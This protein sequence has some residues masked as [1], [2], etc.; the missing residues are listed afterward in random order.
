MEGNFD[1]VCEIEPPVRPDLKQVRHQ[2][3]ALSSLDSVFLIPDNVIPVARYRE[4]AARLEAA[5]A[6]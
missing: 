4:I 2:T 1:V 5:V 3:G 6:D